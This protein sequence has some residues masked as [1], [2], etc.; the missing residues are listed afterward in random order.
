M[1][2]FHAFAGCDVVSA[3]RNKGEKTA[4]QTWDI[5][6]EATPV[7]SKQSQH[8]PTIEDDDMK[9][10]E[11]FVVLMYDRS[12][13]VNGVDEARLDLF[14]RKQ[15]PY[16]A[17]PPTRA[18]PIQHTKL[19]AYQAACVW[20][21]SILCQTETD[22]P[23]DWGW[24]KIDEKWK[25]VWTT[26]SPIAKSCEKLTK[27]GCKSGCRGRCKTLQAWSHMHSLLQLQM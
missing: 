20:S 17:I 6:P 8:P 15:R 16:E 4:W 26:N 5:F 24:E 3:F 9:I 19:A 1:L 11:K 27:C 22:N 23:A 25:V 2:F 13:T 18:A 7:F 10:L 14:A 12:S 21:Q